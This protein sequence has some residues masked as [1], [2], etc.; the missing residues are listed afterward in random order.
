MKFTTCLLAAL[1]LISIGCASQP[2]NAD[3]EDRA[4]SAT[5]SRETALD[6]ETLEDSSSKILNPKKCP[7]KSKMVNG[8]CTLQV[9]SAD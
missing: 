5:S 9:E 2:K 3:S 1:T 8:K 7:R 6:K 4:D